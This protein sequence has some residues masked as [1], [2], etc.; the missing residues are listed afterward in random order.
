MRKCVRGSEQK[1]D[2]FQLSFTEMYHILKRAS[3]NTITQNGLQ[4]RAHTNSVPPSSLGYFL[5]SVNR[6]YCSF[7]F[8]YL[9][10]RI[11]TSESTDAQLHSKKTTINTKE[12]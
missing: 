12:M 6:I 1:T 5:V 7:Q 8:L 10:L 9:F 4:H 11:E 2:D 3:I